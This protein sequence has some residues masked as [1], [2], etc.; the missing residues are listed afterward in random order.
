[1]CA[2]VSKFPLLDLDQQ[3]ELKEHE[4]VFG[5]KFVSNGPIKQQVFETYLSFFRKDLNNVKYF[6]I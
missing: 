4:L 3:I 2:R 6:E 1:M 5:E